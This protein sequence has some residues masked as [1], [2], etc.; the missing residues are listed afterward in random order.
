MLIAAATLL[1]ENSAA[2]GSGLC[3]L[4]GDRGLADAILNCLMFAPLGLSLRL[5]GVRLRTVVLICFAT[6][7]LIEVAQVSIVAGRDATLGDVATNTLGGWLG[8]VAAR[9]LPLLLHPTSR[10]AWRLLVAASV[11]SVL[12]AALFSLL[13]QPSVPVG[14]YWGQWNHQLG[15]NPPYKGSVIAASLGSVQVPPN[16][17]DTSAVVQWALE[18]R[19]PLEL[20]FVVAA[21]P[22]RPATLFSIGD[23]RE[24]ELLWVAVDGADL[25]VR[26]RMRSADLQLDRTTFRLAGAMQGSR[27]GVVVHARIQ[28]AHDRVTAEVAGRRTTARVRTTAAWTLLWHH[29]RLST[30][31]SALLSAIWMA[32]LSIPVAG[33][34]I[35]CGSAVRYSVL[36]LLLHV[37]S[38]KLFSLAPPEFAAWL[39]MTG[40]LTTGIMASR[41][42]R[43]EPVHHGARPRTFA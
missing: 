13:T 3:I 1:P 25:L 31:T 19:R 4:C 16:R 39:A 9:G 35:F 30:V 29:E 2:V 11:L 10:Q 24:R 27:A 38:A 40:V 8:A 12:P 26:W 7:M 37:L 6:S 42:M 15:D 14:D 22:A 21:P 17:V 18:T 33:A 5:A 36:Y 43:R 23:A 32:L 41:R 34:I 20:E 28:R